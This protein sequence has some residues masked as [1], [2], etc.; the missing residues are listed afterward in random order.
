M[1]KES[2]HGGDYSNQD[3]RDMLAYVRKNQSLIMKCSCHKGMNVRSLGNVNKKSKLRRGKNG[4]IVLPGPIQK[5]YTPK[6][7]KTGG[8]FDTIDELPPQCVLPHRKVFHFF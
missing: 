6:T 7:A 2:I 1:Q 8:S 4:D 3:Y 5:D